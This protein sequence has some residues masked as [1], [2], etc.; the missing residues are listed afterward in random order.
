MTDLLP[1]LPHGSLDL[2]RSLQ[3]PVGPADRI[4]RSGPVILVT[5]AD[6]ECPDCQ[7]FHRAFQQIA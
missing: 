7:A 4:R 2:V 5:C 1:T 6:L 3:V